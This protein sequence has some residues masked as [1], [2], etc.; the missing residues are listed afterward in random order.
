L[1]LIAVAFLTNMPLYFVLLIRKIYNLTKNSKNKRKQNKPKGE[2]SKNNEENK[3]MLANANEN[4]P[5]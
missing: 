3:E 1:P 5:E 4:S 2:E